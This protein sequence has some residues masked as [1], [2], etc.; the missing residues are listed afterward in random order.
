M[1]AHIFYIERYFLLSLFFDRGEDT[2][3]PTAIFLGVI[4]GTLIFS[5]YYFSLFFFFEGFS[6]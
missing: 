6:R 3:V 5:P 1:N 2:R 4:R